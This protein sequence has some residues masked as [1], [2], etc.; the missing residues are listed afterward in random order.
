MDISAT[1]EKKTHQ[2]FIKV[3]TVINYFHGINI[4]LQLRL[5]IIQYLIYNETTLSAYCIIN[6]IFAYG[7]FSRVPTYTLYCVCV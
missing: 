1:D 6:V 2:R 5:H 4:R 3:Y 7:Y